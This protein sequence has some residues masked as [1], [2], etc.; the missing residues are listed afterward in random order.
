MILKIFCSFSST[1]RTSVVP[2]RSILFP[3]IFSIIFKNVP[4]VQNRKIS[5]YADDISSYKISDTIE[6][7]TNSM[8]TAITTINNRITGSG[9]NI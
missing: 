4:E 2:Q 7:A 1:R 8:E 5:I 6:E 9:G 3:L